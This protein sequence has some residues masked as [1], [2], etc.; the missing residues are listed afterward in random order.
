MSVTVAH[1]FPVWLPLTQ[2]WLYHQVRFLPDSV[3][4][5]IICKETQHLDQFDLPQIHALSGPSSLSSAVSTRLF[6]HMDYHGYTRLMCRNIRPDVLH[7]HFGPVG[8]K[9]YRVMRFLP[10]QSLHN[11]KQVV[12]F[13]GRDIDQLTNL[14]PAWKRRYRE[15]FQSVDLVLCEGPYMA[16]KVKSLG[17]PPD[18]IQVH[19]LGID[20]RAI[21]FRPR[22]K[23][24]NEPYKI[25]MA[26]AF[27]PKKG[28]IYGLQALEQMALRYNIEVTIVGDDGGDRESKT[29]KDKIV[30]FIRSS[31]LK[32]RVRLTGFLSQE[33]LNRTAYDHHIYLAP[34]VTAPDGDSEGGAPVS[35][36]EM[37]ASG[38]PV[39]SSNHCD[40]PEVIHHRKNGLLAEE[41]DVNGLEACLEKLLAHPESWATMTR[42]ARNH[43]ET[44]HDAEKQGK[45]LSELYYMINDYSFSGNTLK[46]I[47]KSSGQ[48]VSVSRPRILFISHSGDM[49]GA[50]RS[51][52]DVL[53]RL[54]RLDCYDIRVLVPSKG[55]LTRALDSAGMAY[56]LIPFSR[57]IGTRFRYMARYVRRLNNY[58]HFKTLLQ[59]T[60]SWG[61]D[62]IYTNTIATP[63][64]AWLTERLQR[65]PRHIWHARELP[66]QPDYHSG[67]FDYGAHRS[68][69]LMA[70]TG[71][72]FICNS[73][74]L[75]DQLKPLLAKAAGNTRISGTSDFRIDVIYNGFDT[76]RFPFK[77]TWNKQAGE[78]FYMVMAGGICQRKNYREAIHGVQILVNEGLPLRLDIYGSGSDTD[79][80]Q[81]KNEIRNAGMDHYIVLKGYH[82]HIGTLYSQADLLLITSK[83]E[84]FGRVAVEAMLSGCP[85]VSSDVGA[86]P[87]VICN[88]ETGLLYRSG[89]VRELAA[90]VKKICFDASLRKRLAENAKNHANSSY[91]METCISALHQLLQET[92]PV[93]KRAVDEAISP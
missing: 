4:S 80:K 20:L 46:Y 38:M 31:K 30:K 84:T 56:R 68:F 35:L 92:L 27:L 86:L 28:F 89:N 9:N 77:E 61:P 43:I 62:I 16:R 11:L 47:N 60:K 74:F 17:C 88:G 85:V 2:T 52:F 3:N 70:R 36:I 49:Y 10:S 22:E 26:A 39:V 81:L 48:P 8:W 21:A 65:R 6:R 7:S 67:F 64:G 78:W 55:A 33:Q 93:N 41:R 76:T 72:R 50:E 90:Q 45:R 18:I 53:E 5:H 58:L 57:W 51:L 29:E 23:Q 24:D 63:I 71:D 91:S 32:D 83:M 54:S 37:A 59:E 19:H 42:N 79:V 87:E 12:T 13:Y 66:G 1:S 25:L 69:R 15:M 75:S 73:R 44:Q 82:D 14:H 34:S 40:I